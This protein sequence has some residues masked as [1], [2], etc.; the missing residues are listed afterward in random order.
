MKP[1]MKEAR[2][3]C[4]SASRHVI[5][6]LSTAY[7]NEPVVLGNLNHS[8]M[9]GLFKVMAFQIRPVLLYFRA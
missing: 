5:E 8:E 6:D 3:R 4:S 9:T 2:E 1:R 7:A